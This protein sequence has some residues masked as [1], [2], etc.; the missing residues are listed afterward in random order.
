[1]C[2]STTRHDSATGSGASS[3]PQ[4]PPRLALLVATGFGLGYL[5]QAPGTWG[6]L[7]GLFIFAVIYQ[8]PLGLEPY[9]ESWP[10]GPFLPFLFVS[11]IGVWAANRVADGMGVADP[12]IVV[13]DEIAGQQLSLFPMALVHWHPGRFP[14][15]DL[16]DQIGWH[17]LLAGFILFRVFDI[18]KPWPVRT[19]ERLP[20]GWGIMADD[21]V[22]GVYAA[23]CLWGLRAA[24]M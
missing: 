12:G 13:I 15:I 1:V 23:L 8:Y 20:G 11:A 21:W 6:S 2:S 24:G 18:W 14:Y 4:K 7:A 5:P 3:P 22:A 9:A 10:I 19:A 16:D 17:Y